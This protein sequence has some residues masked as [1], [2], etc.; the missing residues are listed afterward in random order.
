MADSVS[1]LRTKIEDSKMAAEDETIDA[2]VTLA[3]IEFGKGN[4]AVST[5]HIDGIKSIVRLRGGIEQVKRSSP[6]TARMISW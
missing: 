2:V 3:A 6:L 1:L 5:M 4:I